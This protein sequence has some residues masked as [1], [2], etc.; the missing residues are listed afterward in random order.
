MTDSHAAL[1]LGLTQAA[2]T[3]AIVVDK[4]VHRVTGGKSLDTRCKDLEEKAAT[5]HAKANDV[6]L[7]IGQVDVKLAEINEHLRNTDLNV[8][9]LERRRGDR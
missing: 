9:R 8:A 5:M 2:L 3:I 4:W 1:V 7:K 6:Q